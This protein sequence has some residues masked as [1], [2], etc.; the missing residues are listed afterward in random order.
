MRIA[1]LRH[2]ATLL[3]DRYCGSRDIALSEAGYAAMQTAVADRR[4][5]RIV[6][7]PLQRC[8]AF[9]QTLAVR[10][11]LSCVIDER[12]RELHFGDWEGRSAAELQ[13]Q[14]AAALGRFWRDPLAHPPPNSEP[15]PALRCRV[16]GAW[17]ELLES[18]SAEQDV[19]VVTH[20]GPIRVL[21]A[22]SGRLPLQTVPG[23][24][25]P[26]A[27]LHWLAPVGDG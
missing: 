1:L 22:E 18:A 3:P 5:H 23:I 12:W 7:S 25:V 8:A 2:G 16:L 13:E 20:G 24:D 6:S 10:H 19:L 26:L 21:L 27:S 9:A 11:K 4:W 14:D 17:R 15:L